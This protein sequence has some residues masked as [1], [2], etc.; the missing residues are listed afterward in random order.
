MNLTK[1]YSFD[2]RSD[3]GYED[4]NGME[5]MDKDRNFIEELITRGVFS[6]DGLVIH[7]SDK[8]PYTNEVIQKIQ[9][10]E[11]NNKWK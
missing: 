8:V 9:N 3:W 11:E 1:D 5:R 4:E 6:A 7:I 10:M 2:D